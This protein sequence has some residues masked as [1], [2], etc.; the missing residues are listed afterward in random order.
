[1]EDYRLP[2]IALYGEL[3]SGHRD[4]GAPKKRYKDTLKRSFASKEE[5][6]NKLLT[7]LSNRTEVTNQMV[8]FSIW[9]IQ[10][11]R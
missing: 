2:K 8:Q 1:M 9:K 4:R 10:Y 11:N 7:L 6:Y 3:S 5:Q